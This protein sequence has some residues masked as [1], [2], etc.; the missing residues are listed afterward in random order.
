M[1]PALSK[2]RNQRYQT[3]IP[4]IHDVYTHLGEWR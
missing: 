1:T 2:A 3:S 4:Q